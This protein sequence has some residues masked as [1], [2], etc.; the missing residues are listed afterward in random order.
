MQSE[1]LLFYPTEE[2]W[3]FSSVLISHFIVNLWLAKNKNQPIP[4]E[5]CG[6]NNVKQNNNET[7]I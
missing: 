7:T 3:V 2:L 4:E 1:P 6:L 5:S